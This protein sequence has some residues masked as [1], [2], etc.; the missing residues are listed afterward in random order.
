MTTEIDAR[1]QAPPD[2][3]PAE[4]AW[5]AAR[6]TLRGTKF[7]L[8][9]AL[10]AVCEP[11]TRYGLVRANRQVGILSF[12]RVAPEVPGAARLT[13]NTTPDLF[14]RQLAGLLRL[15]F[16][17]WPLR[18]LLAALADGRELPPRVFVVTIDDGYANIH[19]YAWP[20]L[21]ELKVPATVLL[22]TQ[23]IDKDTPFPFD[24]WSDK[25]RR[26]VPPDRWVPLTTAQIR[27]MMAD[28]LIEFGSHSHWHKDYR[29]DPAA[30]SRDLAESLVFLRTQFGI[31][32]PS[33]AFPYSAINDAMVK[34]ARASGV[35]CALSGRGR[36]LT[37]PGADPFLLGRFSVDEFENSKTLS[38]KLDGWY[39][40]LKYSPSQ[41]TPQ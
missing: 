14:R 24:D 28:P 11:L 10:A 36:V 38:L 17:P 15:G 30:F 8:L 19:D 31:D 6:H 3:L 35:R 21:R 41:L 4:R 16:E 26:D 1:D 20:I 18:K 9:R 23:F 12:H 33:F 27:A 29:S 40:W 22:A 32:A 7:G 25:G 37:G 13:W 39:D 5:N 34:V 2:R